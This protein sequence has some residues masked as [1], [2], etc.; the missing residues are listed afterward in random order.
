[1]RVRI[2]EPRCDGATGGLHL[3]VGRCGAEV[4][5][6]DDAVALDTD[7]A[8]AAGG[9]GAVEDRCVT[10]D[11]VTAHGTFLLR[12]V[13][14]AQGRVSMAGRQVLPGTGDPAVARDHTFPQ[15]WRWHSGCND[16]ATKP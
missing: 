5:H 3:P 12:E 1:M 14:A 8:A 9:S 6:A 16:P 10:D 4:A 11:Q 2:D 15:R 7:I 13:G